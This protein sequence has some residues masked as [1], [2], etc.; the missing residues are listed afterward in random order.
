MLK[1][2]QLRELTREELLQKR[3]D[4]LDERFNLNMRRS[5]KELDNP[6]RLRQIRREI[7]RINTVLREDELGIRKLADRATSVLPQSGKKKTAD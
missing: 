7:A 5:L 3:N 4:L 2:Q 6:L 1:L